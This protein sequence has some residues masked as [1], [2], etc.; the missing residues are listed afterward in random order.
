VQKIKVA[1]FLYGVFGIVTY[2]PPLTSRTF[3]R[4]YG[5]SRGFSALADYLLC[6][7]MARVVC[8]QLAPLVCMKTSTAADDKDI[9]DVNVDTRDVTVPNDTKQL[10]Q[11]TPSTAGQSLSQVERQLAAINNLLET[12]LRNDA[13]LRQQANKN[14]Q[15]MNGWVVAAAVIDR[16]C[17]IVFSVTLAVGSLIFCL[18][19]LSRRR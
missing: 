4:K 3:A 19:F 16:I 6:W 13:L 14:Q 7:Q 2:S 11:T 15:M 10:D 18:L 1:S 12:K 8:K 5:A 9:S 17:F